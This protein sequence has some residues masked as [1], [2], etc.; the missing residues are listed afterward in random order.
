[1]FFFS[2]SKAI[3]ALFL[4]IFCNIFFA[5]SVIT[6]HE[7][8]ELG[9]G[10]LINEC[11]RSK[12]RFGVIGLQELTQPITDIHEL[13]ER[14]KRIQV[15]VKSSVIQN[16]VAMVLKN[17]T[18]VQNSVIEYFDS[19]S[20]LYRR[21]NRFYFKGIPLIA[22]F[23]NNNQYVLNFTFLWEATRSAQSML[24]KLLLFGLFDEWRAWIYGENAVFDIKRGLIEK[25]LGSVIKQHK[26]ELQME[27]LPTYKAKHY[28]DKIILGKGTLK[29][30]Y[31][32]LH[33]GYDC[34]DVKY[35]NNFVE[36]T[37]LPKPLAFGLAL[38]SVLAR[39]IYL[40]NQ[41]YKSVKHFN[42]TARSI[43]TLQH[44]CVD[45]SQFF[46]SVNELQQILEF[47][48]GPYQ[49]LAFQIK[50]VIIQKDVAECIALSQ[51]GTFAKKGSYFFVYG[52][53]LHLH[54]KVMQITE[55][56]SEL[57]KLVG[58]VDAYQSLATLYQE[59]Q[60]TDHPFT[61]VEFVDLPTPMIDVKHAWLPTIVNSAVCNDICIGAGVECQNM[62]ITGPNGGGKTAYQKLQGIVAFL[63]QSWGIVPAISAKMSLFD[64]I[65][66][67]LNPQ[68]D[69]SK[70]LSKFMAQKLRMSQLQEY[71]GNANKNNK[72]LVLIDEPYSGTVD[73]EAAKRICQFGQSV[74]KNPYALV[75]ISTHVK[76]P[77]ELEKTTDGVFKNYQVTIIPQKNGLFVRTFKLQRGP[78][79]WWF[80]NQKHRSAYIDWIASKMYF[81]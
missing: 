54:R 50:N 49:K 29:D 3:I 28:A 79:H 20:N 30:S 81:N 52:R 48:G 40:V 60:D 31:T 47:V 67:G 75:T 53:V 9:I 37:P 5:D 74:S 61:F 51:T 22:K 69:L 44:H 17:I 71:I 63:A 55:Q 23:F 68:E 19:K 33:R 45:L 26:W 24:K 70:G 2:R 15:F 76:Q 72:L 6:D 11:N 8:H 59:S 73:D 18:S 27:D 21:F 34:S 46:R 35:V 12:T 78:A 1:M 7:W 62:L 14:Q 10:D 77:I 57:V 65:Y 32:L 13:H 25:G 36:Q 42:S 80:D 58:L 56:L 66:T 16:R 64:H 43:K 38:T 4:I 39:D 41:A